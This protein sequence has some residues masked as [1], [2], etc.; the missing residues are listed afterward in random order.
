[1]RLPFDVRVGVRLNAHSPGKRPLLPNA[2]CEAALG[3]RAIINVAG[4]STRLGGAL[5]PPEVVQATS[6][7]ALDSVSMTEIQ[8]AASR[9]IRDVTGAEAGYVT[10]G[11]SSALTLG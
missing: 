1:M 10:A 3:A 8:A 6:E 4:P 5:M 7:A 11:A 9:T 2:S